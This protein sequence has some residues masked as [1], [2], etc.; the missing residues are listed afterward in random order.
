MTTLAT[1]DYDHQIDILRTSSSE[2]INYCYLI[3]DPVSRESVIIDP[4]WELDTIVN[5]IGELGVRLRAV[6]LTHSHYDHVHLA[7]PL[8]KM[9]GCNVYMSKIEID[10][11]QFN[12]DNL[13]G[14]HHLDRIVI[15]EMEITCLHTPGHSAGGM[16]FYLP[17]S[18]FTGDT[19]FTEG[20]GTCHFKGGS[21]EQM[22]ESIE[23]IKT[24]LP[25]STRIYPGHSYGHSPGYTI[26][27]L[28]K[29]NIY[30]QLDQ[31]D[32]F[33]SFR[34]RGNQKRLFDFR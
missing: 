3:T 16:C 17:S 18:L 19:I 24:A 23:L 33:I 13:H 12:C 4:A 15:G 26:S 29:K 25:D 27:E 22:F 10:Y 1:K 34:M 30:F 8:V 31:K 32:K 5:R 20:C 14:L 7:D 21:A 6:L 2:F 11:Y 28:M 9:Y